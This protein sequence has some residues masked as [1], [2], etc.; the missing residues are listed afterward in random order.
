MKKYFI[1][2]FLVIT[3]LSHSQ[4]W[5]TNF[6]EAKLQAT[7]ENK[8]IL[9][10][11]S[12]S[13]W[14]A[15]CIRLDRNVWQSEA[16]KLEAEKNWVLVKVDFPKKKDHQLA[17][18]LVANNKILAEKYNNG[19]NFPLVELLDS[20]GKVNGMIGFENVSAQ[21]YIALIHALEK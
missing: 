3:S 8:K 18:E 15:Q 13:D 21:E 20:S 2:L 17:S 12:G 19:G 9:L 14:C 7:Q 5:K 6:E 10:V 11:F 4:Q 1:F 16:F